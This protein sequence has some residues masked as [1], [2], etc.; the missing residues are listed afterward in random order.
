[1]WGYLY[2]QIKSI[3]LCKEGV[4]KDILKFSFANRVIEVRRSRADL[5][6]VLKILRGYEGINEQDFF[7]R[8]ISNTTEHSIKLC[9]EGVRK[10]ILK[11][12]FANVI[13][14]WN[15]LPEEVIIATSIN[16]FKNN[17]DKFLK[18]SGGV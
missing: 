5:L 3:K 1:L 12:S 10:D 2:L 4:R 18:K 8:H 15:K 14:Q 11:F 7:R 13:E 16:G 6:E 17:V 9:K